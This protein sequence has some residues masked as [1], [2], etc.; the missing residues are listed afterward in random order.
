[1]YKHTHTCTHTRTRTRTHIR[2]THALKHKKTH[3]HSLCGLYYARCA[4]DGESV[5]IRQQMYLCIHTHTHMYR[6]MYVYIYMCI[7]I[8]L[9]V[10]TRTSAPQRT[11]VERLKRTHNLITYVAT[12]TPIEFVPASARRRAQAWPIPDVAPVTT[13]VF[14]MPTCQCWCDARKAAAILSVL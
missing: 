3:S 5:R 10:Q 6:Y 12:T 13:A 11:H 2:T 9:Y 8:Q 7:C 14:P 4:E 1:M